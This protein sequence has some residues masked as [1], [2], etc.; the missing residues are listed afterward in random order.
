VTKK[1]IEAA[2]NAFAK[3]FPHSIGGSNAASNERA[4]GAATLAKVE[5]GAELPAGWTATSISL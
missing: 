5:G 1:Q 2:K 3:R 4:T